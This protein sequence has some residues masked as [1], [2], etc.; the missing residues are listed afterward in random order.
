MY[1]C[2]YGYTLY[3]ELAEG[4]VQRYSRVSASQPWSPLFDARPGWGLNIWVTL[5]PAKVHSAFH[6]SRVGKWVPAYTHITLS[7]FQRRLYNYASLVIVKRL[8]LSIVIQC[9]CMERA[10]YKCT[11]FNTFFFTHTKLFRCG[12]VHVTFR[13][14][15]DHR[16]FR[17]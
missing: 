14:C 15:N 10:L 17:F 16:Y 13:K 11:A 4:L 9:T 2:I 12:T 1:L 5:F 3:T 7:G 6:P 8:Q